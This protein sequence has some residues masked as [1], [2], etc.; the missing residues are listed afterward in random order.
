M[1]KLHLLSNKFIKKY[2]ILY[3]VCGGRGD[4]ELA[5]SYSTVGQSQQETK[6]SSVARGEHRIPQVSQA[7][8]TESL[9]LITPVS[10]AWLQPQT[11]LG[12]VCPWTRT[13]T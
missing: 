4:T 1:H 9:G 6:S 12:Q 7:K 10:R 3:T 5:K 2:T 13:W 8:H 11:R